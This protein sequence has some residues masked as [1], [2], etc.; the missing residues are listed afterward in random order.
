MGLCTYLLFPPFFTPHPL[1]SPSIPND[2]DRCLLIILRSLLTSLSLLQLALYHAP[3]QHV[4]PTSSLPVPGCRY[5]KSLPAYG[6]R[7][8]LELQYHWTSC[9]SE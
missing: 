8:V 5:H 9:H 2:S 7:L 4:L 1:L 6:A 3:S